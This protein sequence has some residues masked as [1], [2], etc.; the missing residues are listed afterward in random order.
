MARRKPTQDELKQARAK[1]NAKAK[2][3]QQLSAVMDVVV[4]GG[5]ANGVLL[6]KIRTDATFIELARP[7]YIKPLKSALQKHPE[8]VKEKDR[9]EVHPIGLTNSG[10]DPRTHIFGVAVIH[11][12]SLTW[13]FSQL[14]IG[15]VENVTSKLV[16]EGL[17]PNK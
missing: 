1:R 12:Q 9:Y 15:Y 4:I 8:V 7:D 6:K 11:G 3:E 2:P 16:A 5:C 14:V 17:V 10:F 13:A